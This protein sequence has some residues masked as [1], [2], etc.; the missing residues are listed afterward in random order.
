M[1][2]AYPILC[3]VLWCTKVSQ[4]LPTK[5]HTRHK[6]LPHVMYGG[7]GIS[8]GFGA[9]STARYEGVLLRDVLRYS[10]LLTPEVRDKAPLFGALGA[11]DKFIFPRS[12]ASWLSLSLAIRTEFC[13]FTRS[14]N[15]GYVPKRP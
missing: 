3:D 4:R 10:G 15:E 9:I 6:C 1:M 12:S 14:M 7:I 2:S 8:W 5:N 11:L 13:L